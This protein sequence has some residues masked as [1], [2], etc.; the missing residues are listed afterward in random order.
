MTK[1]LQE[2]FDT[3]T[4]G[5]IAQGGISLCQDENTC[6]YRGIDG[7]KCAIGHLLSDE[8]I[9]KYSIREGLTPGKF[10]S[11]L[12]HELLPGIQSGQAVEFLDDLQNM[13]DTCTGSN[14]VQTFKRLANEIADKW[15]LKKV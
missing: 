7:K 12:V 3:A 5:V 1:A 13:H 2:A 15:D 4:A 8:Q 10:P 6:A 9:Q 14:F 11:A